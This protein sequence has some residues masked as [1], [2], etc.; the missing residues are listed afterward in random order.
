M[1]KPPA[2][3]CCIYCPSIFDTLLCACPK[4][5]FLFP[6]QRFTLENLLVCW[7]V[8]FCR[9][10]W[11]EVHIKTARSLFALMNYVYWYWYDWHHTLTV[12]QRILLCLLNLL[13]PCLSGNAHAHHLCIYIYIYYKHAQMQLNFWPP[14]NP[15]SPTTKD[16]LEDAKRSPP[17]PL[18]ESFARKDHHGTPT[19]PRPRG[20]T[21]P[22]LPPNGA[23]IIYGTGVSYMGVS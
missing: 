3:F 19:G 2:R 11:F 13:I 6:P 14:T 15:I 16:L 12:D 20:R 18:L 17:R 10:C 8:E 22:V 9:V 4:K 23:V 1:L 21:S 5:C 7:L